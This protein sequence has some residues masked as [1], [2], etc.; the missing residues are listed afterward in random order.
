R[1]AAHDVRP[2]RDLRR[3]RLDPRPVAGDGV[4]EGGAGRR[5]RPSPRRRGGRRDRAVQPRRAPA[6]PRTG[7]LPPAAAG[8]GGRRVRR[9]GAPRHRHHVRPG[10]RR[11]DRARGA[12][13]DDRTRLPLRPDGRRPRRRRPHH[14][15]PARPG[16]AHHAPAGRRHPRR[17]D[18]RPRHPARAPGTPPPAV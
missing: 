5:G 18:P 17:A 13:H 1:P 11:G 2:H 3:P 12:L 15:D 10:R 7:A 16:G 9:G 4:G 14:R 8:R 6:R